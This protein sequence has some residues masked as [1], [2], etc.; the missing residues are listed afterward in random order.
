MIL[1]FSTKDDTHRVGACPSRLPVRGLVVV[2]LTEPGVVLVEHVIVGSDLFPLGGA[3]DAIGVV[4]VFSDS[5]EFLWV[6]PVLG[7]VLLCE[8]VGVWSG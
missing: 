8:G 2:L 1:M 7:Q 3:E 6:L 5:V 4:P